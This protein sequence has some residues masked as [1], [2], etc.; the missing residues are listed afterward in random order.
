MRP[1]HVVVL[2]TLLAFLAAPATARA[3]DEVVPCKDGTTSPAG[4]GACSGHGGVDKDK[5][6]AEKRAAA[7]AKKAEKEKAKADK[8]AAADAKKAEKEKEAAKPKAEKAEQAAAEG[9]TVVCKDGTTSKAGRGACRGHGGIDKG[10]GAGAKGA[11]P[12][13][14]APPPAP[15]P[16]RPAPARAAPPAAAGAAA[17]PANTDPTGA[18]AKCKDGTYSHAKGHTGACSRHGGVAEWLDGTK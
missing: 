11:A 13:A 17:N 1:S 12:A 14:S 6:K 16:A 5:Q 7:D 18:I 10:A 8:K 15:S 4:R 2:S 9:A 3:K